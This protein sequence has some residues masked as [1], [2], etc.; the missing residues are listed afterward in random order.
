VPD[1]PKRVESGTPLTVFEQRPELYAIKQSAATGDQ[2]AI[3]VI[4][5]EAAVA[6]GIYEGPPPKDLRAEE[7]GPVYSAGADGPLAVPTGRVFVR[8]ADNVR[9]DKRAKQFQS[10]G[11]TIDKLLSYAPNAAWLKPSTGGVAAALPGLARLRE[12]ASVEHVE[13]QLLLQR[14]LKR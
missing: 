8:L 3:A 14:E 2:H 1:Y 13:P 11:F 4:P 6:F 5:D 12:V 7:I 10:A 9:A